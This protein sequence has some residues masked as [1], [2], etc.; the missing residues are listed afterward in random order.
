[1]KAWIVVFVKL[2]AKS[3]TGGAH[4]GSGGLALG[5]QIALF[6]FARRFIAHA[7]HTYADA[8]YAGVFAMTSMPPWLPDVASVTYQYYPFSSAIIH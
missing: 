4:V 2:G 5:I 6:F 3:S 8:A 1:M 7:R